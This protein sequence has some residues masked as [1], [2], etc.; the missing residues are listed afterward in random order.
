[1]GSLNCLEATGR[2]CL[3]GQRCEFERPPSLHDMLSSLLS[4]RSTKNKSP[5]TD[6]PLAL[7]PEAEPCDDTYTESM[8]PATND[9]NLSPPGRRCSLMDGADCRNKEGP[10]RFAR[11]NLCCQPLALTDCDCLCARHSLIVDRLDLNQSRS[12]PC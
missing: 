1:M 8:L 10:H 11:T 7:P 4:D 9:D 3:Q 12:D 5:I 6:K 2:P